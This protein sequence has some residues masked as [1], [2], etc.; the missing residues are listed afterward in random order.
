[1]W[2]IIV[3]QIWSHILLIYRKEN[4]RNQQVLRLMKHKKSLNFSKLC[5]NKLQHQSYPKYPEITATE[6]WR[7]RTS[8]LWNGIERTFRTPCHVLHVSLHTGLFSLTCYH[9]VILNFLDVCFYAQLTV[10]RIKHN[11][12]NFSF[13]DITSCSLVK[14]IRRFGGTWHF[15]FQ[16]RI[17]SQART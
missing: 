7:G 4:G 12:K 17:V 1:M 15:L 9:R 13:S 10:F 16:V 11:P 14:V 5:C 2:L 3:V 8:V 6:W